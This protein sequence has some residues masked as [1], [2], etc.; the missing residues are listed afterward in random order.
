MFRRFSAGLAILS[1]S[2]LA[3]TVA[4][5]Q[6][7][8]GDSQISLQGSLSTNIG[9]TGGSSYTSGNVGGSYGY[10]FTRQLALRG[11]AY[12][13]A[14][15]ASGGSTD[16]TGIYGG[17]IE[18]N[19]TGA[20]QPF[21]PYIAFDALTSSSASGTQG[22]VMLGPTVG[23]RAFVSR[24]T[25]FNVAMQYQTYSDN[26]QVGTLQTSF[27]FSVFFGGDRRR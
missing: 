4:S 25:A 14:A 5:A 9:D 19:L 17:G 3:P 18:L 26:T 23:A 10:Y 20:N 2:F 16:I 22:S 6:I 1:A 13:T 11:V 27:G 21:V 8:K 24:N 15:K 7:E 12:I